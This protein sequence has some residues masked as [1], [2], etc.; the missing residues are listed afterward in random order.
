MKN[1]EFGRDT[2]MGEDF[3][4]DQSIDPPRAETAAE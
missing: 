3:A 4:N 2:G 1:A